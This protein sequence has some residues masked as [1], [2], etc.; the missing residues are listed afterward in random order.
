MV[1]R[2]EIVVSGGKVSMKKACIGFL[3]SL[4][5]IPLSVF[6]QSA[7]DFLFEIRTDDGNGG[8]YPSW[9]LAPG[10][11]NQSYPSTTSE[12]LSRN[13]TYAGGSTATSLTLTPSSEHSRSTDLGLV[14]S[15]QEAKYG[16]RAYVKGSK[17]ADLTASYSGNVVDSSGPDDDAEALFGEIPYSAGY[18]TATLGNSNSAS[19]NASFHYA[20][21]CSP[22]TG[23]TFPEYPGETYYLIKQDSLVARTDV[24]DHFL[25]SVTSSGSVTY[26]GTF[27]LT[28]PTALIEGPLVLGVPKPN[29]DPGDTVTLNNISFD[30][31]DGT[32][33]LTSICAAAWEVT[34][35]DGVITNFNTLSGISLSASKMGGWVVKLTV[36]DNDGEVSETEVEFTVGE[37]RVP[38][39]NEEDSCLNS[40]DPWLSVG[41]NAATGN[42]SVNTSN[43]V[44]TRGFPLGNRISLNTQTNIPGEE[45][46]MG[47][48]TFTYG[49]RVIPAQGIFDLGV[50][51]YLIDSDGSEWNYGSFSNAPT[52]PP[53]AYSQLIQTGSGFELLDAGPPGSIEKTGQFKYEFNTSG[54]LT[55]IT[56]P[57]GN[58]Q[59][60]TYVSGKPTLVT[61]LSTGKTIEFL[62]N[63]D[64]YIDTVKENGNAAKTE[65]IYLNGKIQSFVLKDSAQNQ[66]RSGTIAYDIEGRIQNVTNGAES[67]TFTYMNGGNSV[68]LANITHPDG[69][70]NYNYTTLPPLGYSFRTTHTNAKSGQTFYDLDS[71]LNIKRVITPIPAGALNNPT[72]NYTY[73]LDRNVETASNGP[74]TY[75]LT[76]D[77][78]G[79]LT[80]VLDNAG[81]FRHYAY[82]GTNLTSINDNIGTLRTFTYGNPSLPHNPTTITDGD[83]DIWQYSYNSHG[84]LRTITPPTGSP[85]GVVTITYDETPASPF[86]G[87][88]TQIEN[89]AGDTVEFTA[90]DGLGNV[91]EE[92]TH[93]TTL[94][95]D[96]ETYSY[97]AASRL[98]QVEHDDGKIFTYN[99]VGRD[100]NDTINFPRFN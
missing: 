76:Y 43:T 42:G 50:R 9:Q 90:Y 68:W 72:F 94:L 38:R 54:N 25:G 74:T 4:L 83:G 3:F 12:G 35:P 10:S 67:Y 84:Q 51:W 7:P 95:T 61:D 99:Y 1:F 100:L 6:A 21:G 64:G 34:A 18:I 32:T 77:S 41:T 63:V 2:N 16:F 33:P 30:S 53:A 73:D 97:D 45:T 96:T 27:N 69:A 85:L 70:T 31:D 36:T 65:I 17:T 71:D 56:D 66:V 59:E 75:T 98:R 40:S 60:L 81:R 82:T 92:K 58:I 23:S 86:Y 87:Y 78:L 14:N 37:I 52:P 62:Y 80:D 22:G 55:S 49:I 46:V 5:L 57:Q 88:P 48:G 93:P 28:P 20:P 29:P 26:S 79:Q 8:P 39:A 89:G 24:V 13:K 47:N 11:W 19:G 44:L 15:F 91:T